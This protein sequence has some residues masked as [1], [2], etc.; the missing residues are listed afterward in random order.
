VLALHVDDIGIT[1]ASA[2]HTILLDVI[3]VRPVIVFF[4]ALLL[5]Q[6]G[7]FQEGL[8]RPLASGRVRGTVLDRGMSVA[9]VAEVVDVPGS[10]EGP[11]CERMNRCVSPLVT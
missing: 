8:A 4:P 5:V 3:V 7:Q 6:C 1:S 2:P 9:E 10:E 11:G